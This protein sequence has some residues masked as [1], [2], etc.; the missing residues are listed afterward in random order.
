VKR[1]LIGAAI[2]VGIIAPFKAMD[3]S[4]HSAP[5]MR[6]VVTPTGPILISGPTKGP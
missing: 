5:N 3:L 1:V 2:V 4:G 6:A